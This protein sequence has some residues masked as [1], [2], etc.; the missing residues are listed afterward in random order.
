M[1]LDMKQLMARLEANATGSARAQME[2]ELTRVQRALT[3]SEGVRLKAK[4][5]LDSV[6]KALATTKE[7]CRK[8]EEEICWLTHERLSLIMEL[9]AGK[10]E[11]VAF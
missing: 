6:Q 10:E 5:E 9:G 11:L 2:Y 7:T 3:T 8:A 1:P 4:F